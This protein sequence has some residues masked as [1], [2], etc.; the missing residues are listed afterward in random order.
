MVRNNEIIYGG[1]SAG[2]ILPTPT[3]IG[4]QFGDD[5]EDIP[6]HYNNEV[7]WEGLGLV[8]YRIVPHYESEWLG[9]EDMIKELKNKSLEYKTLTDSQAIIINDDKEELLK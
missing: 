3:L 4:V 7:I 8:S 5:P 6:K 2:A 9:A 1:E